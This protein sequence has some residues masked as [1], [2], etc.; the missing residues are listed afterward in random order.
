MFMTQKSDVYP[1]LKE[2]IAFRLMLSMNITDA[3]RAF[4]EAIPICPDGI[5]K[6]SVLKDRF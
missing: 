2:I 5:F 1:L 4:N 3:D 6:R